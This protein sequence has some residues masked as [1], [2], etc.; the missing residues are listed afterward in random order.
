MEQ[1]SD[2]LWSSPGAPPT[3][4]LSFIQYGGRTHMSTPV[5]MKEGNRTANPFLCR[6]KDHPFII[7]SL[8]LSHNW[9]LKPRPESS[10]TSWHRKAAARFFLLC[11]VPFWL[12]QD[13]QWRANHFKVYIVSAW[14]RISLWTK[15]TNTVSGNVVITIQKSL[16]LI[17]FIY[18][19]FDAVGSA[20][21]IIFESL[22]LTK[23]IIWSKI[24]NCT[25][26]N[27]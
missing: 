26:V 25:I 17:R 24:Q 3:H 20:R 19:T 2:K 11:P 13:R 9:I 16:G 23:A 15:Q 7:F 27:I 22:M 5:P 12:Y 14:N 4:R 1:E 6:P 10:S 8:S 21:F 18:T